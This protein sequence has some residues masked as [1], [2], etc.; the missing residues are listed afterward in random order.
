M[1]AQSLN[2]MVKENTGV[3]ITCGKGRIKLRGNG[4]C[5]GTTVERVRYTAS[6]P[7]TGSGTLPT[8]FHAN[9]ADVLPQCHH[10]VLIPGAKDAKMSVTIEIRS[11]RGKSIIRCRYN[12]VPPAF[13]SLPAASYILIPMWASPSCRKPSICMYV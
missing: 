10:R 5:D 9:L 8:M 2:S 3:P 6:N 7:L 13:L 11:K 1:D 12:L 4:Q